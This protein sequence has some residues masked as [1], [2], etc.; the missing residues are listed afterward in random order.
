MGLPITEM[1]RK[2]SAENKNK[3]EARKHLDEGWQRHYDIEIE[4]AYAQAAKWGYETALSQFKALFSDGMA[5]LVRLDSQ[6]D[7]ME[8]NITLR[9]TYDEQQDGHRC[10]LRDQ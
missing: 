2:Y 8:M 3:S 5:A 4:D 6:G 10:P 9:N 7:G 1:A